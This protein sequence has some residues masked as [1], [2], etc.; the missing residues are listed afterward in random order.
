MQRLRLVEEVPCCLVFEDLSGRMVLATNNRR[1]ALCFSIAMLFLTLLPGLAAA[2]YVWRRDASAPRDMILAYSFVA[3]FFGAITAHLATSGV[4]VEASRQ[5][6]MVKAVRC[7]FGI[8]ISAIE[9]GE[10]QR[11]GLVFSHSPPE[12]GSEDVWWLAVRTPSGIIRLARL[13]HSSASFFMEKLNSYY[14]VGN[15]LSR[16][17]G[18]GN[19]EELC[20]VLGYE[21]NELDTGGEDFDLLSHGPLEQEKSRQKADTLVF[22]LLA[23]TALV[24]FLLRK[25]GLLAFLLEECGLA[26]R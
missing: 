24:V 9:A 20:D 5:P 3:A 22:L 16:Q 12:A 14:G 4:R 21:P 11:F 25:I 6:R 17:G 13:P 15:G 2:V 26:P 10:P 19:R 1:A 7:F 18:A 8:T 23:L